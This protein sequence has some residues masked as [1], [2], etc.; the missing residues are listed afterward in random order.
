MLQR[1][2]P[3]LLR[4]LLLQNVQAS[5]R[6]VIEPSRSFDRDASQ[7]LP[8][9]VGVGG[10]PASTTQPRE[11]GSWA[12]ARALRRESPTDVPANFLSMPVPADQVEAAEQF[13]AR[14]RALRHRQ[15]LTQAVAA[16]APVCASRRGGP[17][18]TAP[19][20]LS[21]PESRGS[22]RRSPS[23]RPSC[24]CRG[25]RRLSPRSSSA[26]RRSRGCGVRV[27]RRSRRSR[28]SSQGGSCRGS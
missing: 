1:R 21:L 12:P 14:L 4:V 19:R 20:S 16:G 18:S 7:G 3:S 27:G 5:P 22:R 6:N 24:S 9:R 15:G 11:A 26:P 10:V 23:R 8:A 25:A 17:G 2:R 28:V 13:A